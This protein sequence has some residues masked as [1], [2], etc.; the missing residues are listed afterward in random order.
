MPQRRLVLR[1]D[2]DGFWMDGPG[3]GLD[4]R[5]GYSA[6]IGNKV[7]KNINNFKRAL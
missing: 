6:Q 2:R 4:G 5:A 3:S 1:D 7:S